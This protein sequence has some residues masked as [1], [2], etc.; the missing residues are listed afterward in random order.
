MGVTALLKNSIAE[1]LVRRTPGIYSRLARLIRRSEQMSLAERRAL[2]DELTEK[3]LRQAAT[4]PYSKRAGLKGIY[5]EWPI[6]EKE[7][8]RREGSGCTATT[9]V[10]AHAASTGGTTGIPILLKRSLESV[11]FEQAML[12]YLVNKHA[13]LNLKT[14]RV[15]VLRGDVVKRPDDMM[16]PHWRLRHA[17]LHLICSSFHLNA[18]TINDYIESIRDF[19]PDIL[20]VYPSS[21]EVLVRLGGQRLASERLPGLKLLLASSEVLDASVSAEASGI[22]RA[23]VLNFYGQ[24]E[25]VCASW[26]MTGDE[27]YFLPASGRVELLPAYDDDDFSLYEVIGTSYWNAAQPLVRFRTGDLAKLPRGLSDEQLDAVTLG[28]LPFLGIEGRRSEYVVSPQGGHLVGMNHIPRDVPGIAQMQIVQRQAAKIEVHVVP[29][30]DFGQAS[31]DA[32]LA[33]ARQKIP[34]S[35]E[36]EIKKVEGLTRTKQGKVPLVMRMID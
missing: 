17:G 34:A 13:G 5:D 26:A 30:P 4:T 11:V 23:P 19:R 22:L 20:W 25:R 6:L 3:T 10:P 24:S 36:I 18:A 29:L 16:L 32:I 12:D 35:V 2:R 21:L 8:L 14:A 33:N 9:L 7:V 27:H 31:I 28:V 1:N 15:A